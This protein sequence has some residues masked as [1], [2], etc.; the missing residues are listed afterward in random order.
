MSIYRLYTED[1]LIKGDVNSICAY[2]KINKSRLSRKVFN[3]L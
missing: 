3:K 1:Y 2:N